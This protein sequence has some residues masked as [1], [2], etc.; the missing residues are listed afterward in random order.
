MNDSTASN[1]LLDDDWN[2]DAQGVPENG[3]SRK[4]VTL[5]EGGMVWVGIRFWNN[6]KR[7]W[8]NNN[9]PEKAQILAWRDLP[10]PAKKR[11]VRGQLT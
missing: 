5:L 6:A 1:D 10:E 8:F 11:W 3:D 9:E 7:C 4:I 2:Y